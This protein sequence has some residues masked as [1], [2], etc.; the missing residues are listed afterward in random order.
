[1]DSPDDNA[2]ARHRGEVPGSVLKGA[3]LH[4]YETG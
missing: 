4:V 1:M 3:V 2:I